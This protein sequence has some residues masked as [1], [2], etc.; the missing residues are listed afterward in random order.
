MYCRS[1]LINFTYF[2][3]MNFDS[4]WVIL[5]YYRYP[6]IYF[7]AHLAASK[8]DNSGATVRQARKLPLSSGLAVTC[9]FAIANILLREYASTKVVKRGGGSK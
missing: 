4:A 8:S 7:A 5:H 1:S 2:C 9:L 6:K 3:V